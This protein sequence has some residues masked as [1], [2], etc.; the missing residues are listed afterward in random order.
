MG[1]GKKDETSVRH[2]YE[3]N[4]PKPVIE[5]SK[6][7]DPQMITVSEGT[8]RFETLETADARRGRLRRRRAA[9]S[10]GRCTPGLVP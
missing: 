10:S 8:I 5:R 9:L 2:V 1:K 3:D 4:K 6:E 7:T